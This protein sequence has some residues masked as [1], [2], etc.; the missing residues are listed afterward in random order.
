MGCQ[1][2]EGAFLSLLYY[3]DWVERAGLK[4]QG[5]SS[6]DDIVADSDTKSGMSCPK[7][8]RLMTKYL[9]SGS[10][11]SRLDMCANCDEAWLDGGEWQLLKSLELGNKLPAVFT[12]QWQQKV[13]S[14]KM[15]ANKVARLTKMVGED[16]AEKATQI[17]KWLNDSSNKATLL[18]FLSSD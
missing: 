3:R 5:A 17:K 10:S 4:S 15:E 11:N 7:C 8:S 1:K 18:H 14:K 12:E 9:I 2:C 6:E 13:R 16:D